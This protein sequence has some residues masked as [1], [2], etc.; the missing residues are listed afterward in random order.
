M[1]QEL[2][3]TRSAAACVKAG[4]KFFNANLSRMVRRLWLPALCVSVATGCCYVPYVRFVSPLLIL[5]AGVWMATQVFAF[6]NEKDSRANL[7][8]VLKLLLLSLLLNFAAGA[9]GGF[10]WGL[11]ASVPSLAPYTLY[12][13]GAVALLFMLV[14]VV[15]GLPYYFFVMKYIVEDISIKKSFWPSLK[16]GLRHWGMLFVL[17]LITGLILTFIALIALMPLIV[18]SIAQSLSMQGLM[19]GD[20]AGLP[21]SFVW[22]MAA[23][24]ALTT[25]LMLLLEMWF[26]S[27]LYY[28]YGSIEQQEAERK[29]K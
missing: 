27:V 8:K 17:F 26:V 16:K 14:A 21:A 29:A 2:Y 11:F 7:T 22:L 20:A 28:A 12:A 23:T 18:L 24:I 25:L 6:F 4:N 5:L 3:K 15:F 9:I 10:V 13:L 1:K 19:M